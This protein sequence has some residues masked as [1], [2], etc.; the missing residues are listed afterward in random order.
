MSGEDSNKKSP[1]EVIAGLQLA[2]GIVA[3]SLKMYYMC[4][5]T[6]GMPEK[7]IDQLVVSMQTILMAPVLGI[8]GAN[9]D[10]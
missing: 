2:F 9:P 1:E 6:T 7:T 10:E 5:K 3:D 8:G 4:L